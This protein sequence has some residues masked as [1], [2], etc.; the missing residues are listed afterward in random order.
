VA[1]LRQQ[2]DRNRR[3]ARDVPGSERQAR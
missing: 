3:P 2:A 1:A